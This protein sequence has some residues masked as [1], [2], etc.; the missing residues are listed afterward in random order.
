MSTRST[1]PAPSVR[2]GVRR[3]GRLLAGGALTL[4]TALALTACHDG[5][6]LRDEGPSGAGPLNGAAA[7]PRAHGEQGRAVSPARNPVAGP[8]RLG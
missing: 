1:P 7:Q 6:G 3:R 5:Q 4:V 2:R 8:A